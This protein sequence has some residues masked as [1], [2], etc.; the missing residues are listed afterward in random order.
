MVARQKV[1]FTSQERVSNSESKPPKIRHYEYP[2]YSKPLVEIPYEARKKILA[3]LSFLYGEAEAQKYLPELE[4][5]LKVYYAHK[6]PAKIEA[7][8]DLLPAN[9]F[10]EKDVILITYGDL[11]RSEKSSPL[12]SLVHILEQVP[13]FKKAINTLHILPFFPYSSDRGFSV[14]DFRNVD[15]KLGSW[16]D[17]AQIGDSYQLMFDAVC[18]HTSSQSKAFQKLLNGNPEYKDIA[19]VYHS[20]DELSPEDLQKVVRPRTSD[21]LT[22]FQSIDGPIWVWTTFSAD[23]IDL[24]YRNPKVLLWVIETL[25]LYVRRGADLIRL[26]AVTYLWEIP[27]TSCANLEQTHE[28]IKLF[29]DILNVVAP[30]VALITET[31]I[32]HEQNIAYFG[33]GHDEAQ[34]VYNFALPPLVLHTFYRE[35]TTALAK[36]AKQLEFPSD[37]CTYLNILDT[38]DGIGLMGVKNI[39]ASEDIQYLISR[40]REHGAF[41]SYRTG[42]GGQDEP[43]EI[44][45]TWYSALNLDSDDES[46]AIQIKR[47]VASRS[48]ALALKGV[49]G[50]Y[51]HG[52]FG[53]TND[54][55]TVLKTKSKR[56]INRQ[57]IAETVLD[58]QLQR[59]DS[60]LSQLTKAL[61]RLLEIRVCQRAFHPHG[62]QQILT[63]SPQCFAVLRVAPECEEHILTITN[64]S[65]QICQLEIPLTELKLN[66]SQSIACATPEDSYWYDLIGHRGWRVQGQKI[67]LTLQPYDVVWLVPFIELER[68]IDRT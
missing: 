1:S 68:S 2:D 45:T 66:D 6:P 4:R 57:I 61:G 23:Q 17:I 46:L 59:P 5:I 37:T 53:T 19:T 36:W 18:N 32:P 35:D 41:V 8:R 40:A 15:P 3:R 58:E 29:R 14:T 47:F 12:A 54:V 16:Q 64:V 67:S 62:E 65:N 10:T 20:P 28:T 22:K 34:M 51:V 31:N 13:G 21:L 56:D 55:N 38:H 30:G 11:L 52:L 9:R 44:N 24:N 33:N 43:Y 26:D 42:S 50:I 7:E 27:G 48:I 60:K 49:P 39:L 63:L 25:L